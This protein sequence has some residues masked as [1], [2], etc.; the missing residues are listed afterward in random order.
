MRI[1]IRKCIYVDMIFNKD[2]KETNLIALVFEKYEYVT[3]YL[4]I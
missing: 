1:E 3:V 2:V 4:Q